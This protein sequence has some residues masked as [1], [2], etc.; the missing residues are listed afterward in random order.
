VRATAR[1]EKYLKEATNGIFMVFDPDSW[2]DEKLGS[3]KYYS[4]HGE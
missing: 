3:K 2:K 4:I 1:H